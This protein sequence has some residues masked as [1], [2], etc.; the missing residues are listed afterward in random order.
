MVGTGL[1]V[2]PLGVPLALAVL[3][4][5]MVL[6]G[7]KQPMRRPAVAC[8]HRKAARRSAYAWSALVLFLCAWELGMFFSDH[9]QP[10]G[11][12]TYPPLTDLVEPLFQQP[13][14]RWILAVLWLWCCALVVRPRHG[15]KPVDGP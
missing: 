13:F 11:Q 15:T 14:T 6:V 8:I 10:G 3:G 9:F 1:A 4:A 5:L 7:W 12:R 2:V